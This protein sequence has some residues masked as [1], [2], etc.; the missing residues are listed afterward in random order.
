ML[1][2]LDPSHAV[3]LVRNCF[4]SLVMLDEDNNL[5]EWKYIENLNT[6]QYKEGLHLANKIRNRHI[7]FE[8]NKMSV[9]LAVQ[10]LS[11]SVA[12]ALTYLVERA[13]QFAS[14]GATARF[15][16]NFNDAF[17]ILNSRNFISKRKFT[18]KLSEQTLPQISKKIKTL[19]TYILKL[20]LESGV[21]VVNSER[22]TGFRGFIVNLDNCVELFLIL[23]SKAVLSYLLT[24]KISQDH[25]E[26][27]FSVFRSAGGYNNNPSAYHFRNTYRKLLGKTELQASEFA[28]CAELLDI[29]I[30]HVSSA[31]ES[32]V[33]EN[34]KIDHQQ[35]YMHSYFQTLHNISPMVDDIVLYIAG[36]VAKK[37]A[38]VIHCQF[39][40][41]LLFQNPIMSRLV[42]IKTKGFLKN[43]SHNVRKVCR[44]A[45]TAIRATA[46]LNNIRNVIRLK[47]SIFFAL[48]TIFLED[49]MI[50]HCEN[51][52]IFDNHRTQLIKIIISKYVDLRIH[53]I[54]TLKSEKNKTI[55]HKFTKMILF[56]NQ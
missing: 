54:N 47:S 24:Y 20:K 15:C 53:H 37:V 33:K 11:E 10:V 29:E 50:R 38:E 3:K 1:I 26:I 43:V 23:R 12:H 17:D 8:E 34:F 30:L 14:A 36:F 51:Q 22:K 48:D 4:G 21:L 52:N 42:N 9:R 32:I 13:V 5:I 49:E 18:K 56:S 19:K 41:D 39:C 40:S 6:L 31:P 44:T 35:E 25:L 45:E 16:Q 28:N 7:H 46:S 55:R 2:F 27:Y